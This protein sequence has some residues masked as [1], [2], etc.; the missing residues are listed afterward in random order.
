[1]K[2]RAVFIDRDRTLIEAQGLGPVLRPEDVKLL[3]RVADGL[4]RLKQCDLLLILVTNQGVIGEGK[5][6][7][8]TF[9]AINARMEELIQADGGPMLDAIYF[10]P[11]YRAPLTDRICRCGKPSPGMLLDAAFDHYIELRSSY[12]VGD[13]GRDMEAGRAAQVRKCFMISDGRH[14]SEH[15]DLL[16]HTFYEAAKAISLMESFSR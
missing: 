11:H 16:Y 7:V 12:M 4:K 10:C 8:E 14:I 9:H 5:L 3:P 6:A 2:R 13:D 15:A 1:M